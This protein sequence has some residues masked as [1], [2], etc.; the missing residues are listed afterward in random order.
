MCDK[1]YRA[2]LKHGNFDRVGTRERGGDNKSHYMYPAWVMMKQ[3]CSNPNSDQY[4]Y[5]GA[6]GIK[7]CDRWAASFQSFLS[8]VGERPDGHTLDRV[9]TNG[10]YEP[11]NCRWATY[12]QQAFNRRIRRTNTTGLVGISFNKKLGKYVV[13]RQNR[14]TGKRDYLGCTDTLEEAQVLYETPKSKKAQSC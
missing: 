11:S 5:Y 3:R 13:R 9:D 4:Q 6:R 12:Q 10:G 1:H 7:I 14:L 8:D 2:I